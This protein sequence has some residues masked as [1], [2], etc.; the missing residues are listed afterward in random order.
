VPEQHA[1]RLGLDGVRVD[2]QEVIAEQALLLVTDPV[3]LQH[4]LSAVRALHHRV[5]SA[6]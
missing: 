2:R 3:G 4:V 5:T 1:A 6:E